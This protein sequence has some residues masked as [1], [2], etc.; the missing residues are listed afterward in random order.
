MASAHFAY[1]S[2]RA[3][4][5]QKPKTRAG[6][7]QRKIVLFIVG[8]VDEDNVDVVVVVE[9]ENKAYHSSD[10]ASD[11]IDGQVC[12]HPPR[13]LSLHPLETFENIKQKRLAHS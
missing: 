1:R 7:C 8:K 12:I 9:D 11:N 5:F 13:L 4:A 2:L 10:S 3:R 6:R